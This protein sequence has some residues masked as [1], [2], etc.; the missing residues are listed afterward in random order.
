VEG[1]HD[2]V[3]AILQTFYSGMEGGTALAKLLFGDAIPSGKLPF[4]VARQ[5]SDYPYFDKNADRITYD[6]W[7][8]Y[9]KFDRIN[10][11]PRYAFG[12]GLSYTKFEYRA[13]KARVSGDRILAQLSVTN[14][15]DVAADEVVMAFVSFPGT[16]AVRPNKLLKG[17]RRVHIAAHE[18][19]TVHIE[20]PIESLKWRDPLTHSWKLE[21]GEYSV[22]IGGNSVDLIGAA[23]TL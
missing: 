7:H 1:W 16:D 9:S 15:G 4:T 22:L 21:S 18:A 6:H 3:S 14:V 8:G 20:I 2:Q 12:H 19:M 5:A 23:F 17:F 11:T 13:V 10:L